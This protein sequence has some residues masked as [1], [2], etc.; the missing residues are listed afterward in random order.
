MDLDFPKAI[1]TIL[2][3]LLIPALY[4]LPTFIAGGRMHSQRRAILILNV[5]GGWTVLGWIAALTWS[6][7]ATEPE[8]AAPPTP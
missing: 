7:M 4:L 8:K 6:C 1:L 2:L 3:V 5:F